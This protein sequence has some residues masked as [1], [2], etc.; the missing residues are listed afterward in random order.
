LG[1]RLNLDRHD[2]RD[3]RV[4]GR[5]SLRD[6]PPHDVALRDDP[7]ELARVEDDQ[8]AD[9]LGAHP[10][11]DFEDGGLRM[12]G[13]DARGDLG[14]LHDDL[15]LRAPAFVAG[16][17]QSIPPPARKLKILSTP[18]PGS[19]PFLGRGWKLCRA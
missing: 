14:E 5:A 7:D 17:A 15:Y 8:G 10:L 13:N 12:R 16:S 19:R 18:G 3:A 4:S 9:L 2:L 11:G 6:D 1:D